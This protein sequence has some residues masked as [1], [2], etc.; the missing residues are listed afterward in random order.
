MWLD[1]SNPLDPTL[2]W[3]EGAR[4]DV[5]RVKEK[6]RLRLVEILSIKGGRSTPALQRTGSDALA[7]RY[8]SF[9]GEEGTRCLDVEYVSAAAQE[10]F[11]KKFHEL[12]QAYAVTQREKLKGDSVTVR[13]AGIVDGGAPAT[14]VK[15]P[16]A[17]GGGSGGGGAATPAAQGSA[18][19]RQ[20]QLAQ[21]QQQQQQLAQQHLH[22]Q[23]L[24]AA[25]VGTPY[26][27]PHHPHALYP[28]ALGGGGGMHTPYGYGA[29]SPAMAAVVTAAQ[30]RA[31][32]QQQGNL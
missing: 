29:P 10:F 24:A 28:G 5:R 30:Q 3:A 19:A 7:A 16:A 22:Q 2:V 14:A 6:D 9:D 26:M 25:R 11:F 21:Q 17:G 18:A 4:K 31:L 8:M 1:I 23:Q 32:Y 15:S 13:V 20:Q 12:F 27:G